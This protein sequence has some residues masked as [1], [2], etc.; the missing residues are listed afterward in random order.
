MSLLNQPGIQNVNPGC[1]GRKPG[2]TAR[3]AS[4]GLLWSMD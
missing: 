2:T 3:L 1:Q 4:L